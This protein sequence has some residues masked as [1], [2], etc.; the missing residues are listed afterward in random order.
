MSS[1]GENPRPTARPS[2][3]QMGVKTI[4]FMFLITLLFIAVL[5]VVYLLTRQTIRANEARFL[6]RAV[7]AAAG[8]RVGKDAA[9]VDRVFQQRVR[10]KSGPSGAAYYEILPEGGGEPVGYVLVATGAGLWGKIVATVGMKPD[11][12]TLTGVEFIEQQETPG[13]GARISE[14]WFTSQ[15]S[16]KRGPFRTVPEGEQAGEQE[17]Q[18]V[19]G[20]TIT[21]SAVLK[22]VN[23]SLANAPQIIENGK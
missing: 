7:I 14:P 8:L 19:T 21:S 9:E 13:L 20:A 12:S 3:L 2:R 5:S 15:F 18:A 22:I 16:G 11:L 17:F 23:G 4:G 1:T 10:E 6:K